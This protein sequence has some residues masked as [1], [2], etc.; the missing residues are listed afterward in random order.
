LKIL[1]FNW[2]DLNHPAA[3]GAELFTERVASELVVRGHHVTLFVASVAGRPEI[4]IR[5]GVKIVRR[6]SRVGVYREARRFWRTE[7]EG[8]AD[9]VIDEVNTRPFLT[10]HYVRSVPILALVHQLAREI[11]SYEMPF[12]ISTVG[13]YLLE[14]RWLRVYR[15]IPTITDSPSSA[16][17]LRAYGLRDVEPVPM[18]SDPVDLSA[19]E[20]EAIPTVVFLGRLAQMK[21][22]SDAVAAVRRLRHHVPTARLWIL[23]DGPLRGKLER[24]EGEFVEVLG[25]VSRQERE[26]R[27][28]RAHVLVATSVREGWGLNISE[29][30]ACGTPSIGYRVPGLVDSI[31][32]SGGALVD[33]DEAALSEALKRYFRGELVLEPRLSTVPWPRVADDVE[34]RLRALRR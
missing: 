30:A 32:A 27:L 19:V 29:A 17:S 15:E 11:W 12:P 6:G 4:E 9:I 18:G 7:G 14:P 20:K 24:T 13:R 28:A 34:H 8:W 22:P 21:R 1:I 3:G 10:P 16:D 2:K 5:H 26:R 31:P 25:H 33:P 23:G